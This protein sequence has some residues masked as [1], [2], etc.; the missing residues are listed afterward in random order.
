MNLHDLEAFVAVAESGSINRAAFRLHVTQSAAT[1]R[2]KNL[3]AA[4]GDVAL[5]DRSVKP[6]VLTP[7]GR[8]VLEHSRRVLKALAELEATATGAGEPAGEL[9]LGV[10][11]GL[12]EFVLGPPIEDVLRRFPAVRLRVSSNWSSQLIGEIASGSL[13]CA[14]G[15]LTEEMPIPQAVKA[16]R[17]GDE[18]VVVV[19]SRQVKLRAERSRPL[20]LHDLAAQSWVLNPPGCGCRAELQ[21]AFD[22]AQLSLRVGAEF[23]GEDLQLF[24]IA[25]GASL[26]LVPSRQLRHSR[27]RPRLRV[28]KVSDFALDV[29]ITMLNAAAL[30]GLTAPVRHLQ[31]RIAA[32][33]RDYNRRA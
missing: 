3:E 28:V 21:R 30:G 25:H 20:R 29:A 33:I 10:A 17:L 23:F 2:I 12:G 5:L 32:R 8:M 13:D 31:S 24:M 18:R 16:T 9:R 26:G 1:R 11:H 14:I 19:A 22:R 15:L 6:A 4:L 7:I 27:H